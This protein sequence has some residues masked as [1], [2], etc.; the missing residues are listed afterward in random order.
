MT[1]FI[2]HAPQ[3][4]A[5]AES[6]AEK[7][8][9]RAFLVELETGAGAMRPLSPMDSVIGLISKDFVFSPY[10]L[11]LE[12]RL[13][14]AW[15]DGQ[16]VQVKLD[17][18]FAPVGLRDL[19]AIDASF[20][21]QR[22]PFTW[23]K[24]AD[25]VR[26]LQQESFG[27]PPI[28]MHSDANAAPPGAQHSRN[29]HAGAEISVPPRFETSKPRVSI[30]DDPNGETTRPP[31]QPSQYPSDPVPG[32]A[33]KRQAAKSGG[34][35]ITLL[36]LLLIGVGAT[37]YF[38]LSG[39]Q[40]PKSTPPGPGDQ[41]AY[42]T[43]PPDYVPP[44]EIA[45]LY[46]SQPVLMATAI[47]AGLVFMA[48]IAIGA[49]RKATLERKMGKPDKKAL[50]R[51][52]EAAIAKAKATAP[53][54][55]AAEPLVFI[56]YARAD[57]P[58]VDPLA[59]AVKESGHP[60]WIDTDEINAGTSWAGEIVRAIKSAGHVLI[61]C[62]PRSFESDQVKREVYLADRYKKPLMPV[63]LEAA[64]PPEDFEYFFAGVQ[65]LKLHEAPE[66]DRATI[67]TRALPAA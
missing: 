7:L 39:V 18:A 12:K 33:M 2:A 41:P 14:D 21:A 25:A 23:M 35:G 8:R 16:L 1:V 67:L 3:D 60:I 49:A 42:P 58:R 11:R 13:L 64:E 22:D 50:E 48:I 56:S 4:Q 36:L 59:K 51:A 52:R 26:A 57:Q 29:A 15:A 46:F 20:E 32:P 54:P 5:A 45:G 65:W 6:L 31:Q 17:H 61:M 44:V 27:A 24:V 63:F 9:Q 19:P 47:L 38:T 10:K 40:A 34:A 62:S 37:A 55:S 28:D 43:P 30:D 66:A 53:A